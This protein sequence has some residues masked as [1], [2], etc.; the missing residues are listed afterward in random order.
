MKKRILP[1]ALLI[2][3]F[4]FSVYGDPQGHQLKLSRK[5][6]TQ[7]YKKLEDRYKHFID[8]AAYISAEDERDVFFLLDSNRDRDIFVNTFWQLRD[9]TPGT[10]DNEY[11]DEIVRRF[12]YVNK[13]FKRGVGRP[14]WM[15]DMGR[16]YMILG[17]PTSIERFDS[18]AGLYPA[19]VWYYH[20]DKS[21][22]LP[23]YFNITFYK[24]HNT[25]EWKLYHPNVDGP[26]SLLI[27]TQQ[28]NEQDYQALYNKI[29][30][31]APGLAMP[32]I[33]MIPNQIAPGFQPP[34][35]NNIVLAKIEEA[36][37]KKLNLSYATHFL[38]FKGFV[39]VE[40]SV[41]YVDNSRV[42]SITRYEGLDFSFV[43]I[44]L[45]PKR[46]SLGYSNEKDKYYF[47]YELNVS[48][49]R[50]EAFIYQYK[51]NFDFYIDPDRVDSLR[52]N[53]IVIHD[54]FPV[55]PGQYKLMV[56][57]MNSVGKEFAYFD[58]DITVWPRGNRTILSVPIIGFKAEDRR[59]HF[60]FPYKFNDK[61]LYVD[62]ERNLRLKEQPVIHT[63]IYNLNKELWE[64]GKLE[65][66]LRGMNDRTNFKKK[67]VLPLNRYAYKED[68]NI[69]YPLEGEDLK[70]DYY[71][72]I[73]GLI[74]ES[75][76]I[77]ATQRAEFAVSPVSSFA[78][79]LEA[80]KQ[81]SIL[82]PFYF[83]HILGSQYEKVGNLTAA[84]QYL[85]RSIESNPTF[86]E[87][88]IPYLHVLNRVKKYDKV[89][90]AA[91][92]LKQDEKFAFD[93]H[94]ARAT[95]L[96]GQKNYREALK[97]LV[98]ANDIYNSD[99]RVLN[100]LGFTFLNLKDYE[101]ALKAF[102]ASLKLNKDQTFILKTV[103]KVK[104]MTSPKN[105]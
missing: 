82:N 42:V 98:K 60:L 99:V 71:T 7:Q 19:Q 66:D 77:Q 92:S 33:T 67:F 40:E 17:K 54:S 45:K 86:L 29:M 65:F 70:P 68:L 28:F 96:F 22:G 3:C 49:K 10:E 58:K 14:G 15:T 75:G 13:Y 5:E 27:K 35:M 4:V 79:P 85:A 11:K 104:Q 94:L 78:H 1:G 20:G 18:E 9:S 30:E 84:E 59:N 62:P 38:N 52:G 46:I 103:E 101:E 51:K 83:Y 23:T 76:N 26:A 73:I 89:L 44:S 64:K 2:I 87:G 25:T 95:A 72:L 97:E 36:P 88:Y 69:L 31:L 32:A 12:A 34:L 100:L 93:Y 50:G 41:N 48:L 8:M 105:K 57:A 47:N 90:A 91:E 43:N 56:F 39:N 53:G 102:A 63:G 24:P 61:K 74:D 55:I 80:F 81:S 21:L 6:R 37:T 16:F